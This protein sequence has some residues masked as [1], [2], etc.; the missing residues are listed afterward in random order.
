MLVRINPDNPEGRKIKQVVEVLEKGGIIIYPTDT[1]YA[2]GCDMTNKKAVDR[3]ARLRGKDPNQ[4]LFSIICQDIS[5][6]SDYTALI[7]N[8]VF[9]VM[10]HNLPGPF[11]FIL[12]ANNRLPKL[13]KNRKETIGIRIPN[14]NIAQQLITALGRPIISASL[15]SDDAITEYYTDPEDIYDDHRKLVDIVIDGG[16]GGNTPSTIIDCTSEVPVLDREGA[17]QLKA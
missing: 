5:Q 4:A 11:T 9:R 1:V 8:E 6:V 14:N 2:F 7:N 3:L 16:P 12:Q 15:K 17:G 13:L 10:K